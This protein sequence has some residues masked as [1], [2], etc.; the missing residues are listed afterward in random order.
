MEIKIVKKGTWLYD[1]SIEKPVDNI[2][3]EY[4]WWHEL[5]KADDQLQK[6]SASIPVLAGC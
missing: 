4:D 2:A 3:L 6:R 1:R 5:A